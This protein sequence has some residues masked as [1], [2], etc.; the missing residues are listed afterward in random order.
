MLGVRERARGSDAIH[1][2]SGYQRANMCSWQ[3][4]SRANRCLILVRPREGLLADRNER[5]ADDARRR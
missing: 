1:D 5:L 4:M 2:R 3:G